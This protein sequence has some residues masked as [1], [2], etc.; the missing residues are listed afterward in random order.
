M[1]ICTKCKTEKLLGAFSPDNRR[2][3]GKQSQCKICQA[4]YRR[5]YRKDNPEKCREQ[6]RA[7]YRRDFDKI[8]ERARLYRERNHEKVLEGK[9]RYYRLHLDEDHERS[10]K[11]RKA[12][13]ERWREVNRRWISAN[14]DRYLLAKKQWNENNKEKLLKSWRKY[15]KKRSSRASGKLNANIGSAIYH[16]LKG[17]KAG[18]SWEILVGYTLNDL[19]KHL[20]KNFGQG[21]NW[22]NMGKWHLDHKV[23]KSAFNYKTPN[24]LDFKR[25]WAL[26]NLQPLW[27]KDNLI[28]GAKLTKPF[29]PSLA[30]RV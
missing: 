20:E 9:R 10:R 18:R 11:Y 1:K 30:F 26:E 27:A 23:P 5:N 14:K 2:P 12:N 24:D 13:P 21:M 6:D 17:E 25:C 22:E 16:A 7:R 4:E 8:R 15:H 19:M 3:S 29:Q 28:K